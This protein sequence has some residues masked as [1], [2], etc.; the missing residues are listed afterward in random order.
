MILMLKLK[1]LKNHQMS[2]AAVESNESD[3]IIIE[4]YVGP[5]S[6]GPGNGIKMSAEFYKYATDKIKK[7]KQENQVAKENMKDD[8]QNN[9]LEQNGNFHFA[10]IRAIFE[11]I[12]SLHAPK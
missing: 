4:S 6:E 12:S 1:S 10:N 9:V 2:Q 7:E 5:S 11:S 8:P 3:D